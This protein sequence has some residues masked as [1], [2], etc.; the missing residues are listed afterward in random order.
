MTE[1]YKWLIERAR[2]VCWEAPVK[3]AHQDTLEAT[4]DALEAALVR[5]QAAE[6]V[7]EAVENMRDVSLDLKT[8]LGLEH[9]VHEALDAWRALKPEGR[10]P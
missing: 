4:T 9:K 8:A 10:E 7:C 1:D 6:K 5:L 3:F 2:R